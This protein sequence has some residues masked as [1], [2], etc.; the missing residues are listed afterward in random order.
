MIPDLGGSKPAIQQKGHRGVWGGGGNRRSPGS[1]PAV[2][3][4]KGG[5]V[6][7]LIVGDEDIA[8]TIR[9]A[10]RMRWPDS[11]V[12]IQDAWPARHL[13]AHEP[14]D[15]V[16]VW[17]AHPDL[18]ALAL[19]REIRDASDV[20][21]FFVGSSDTEMAAAE[22]LEAGADDYLALP[23]NEP[24][25]VARV[26]AVLRRVKQV[27]HGERPAVQCGD[28][29]IDPNSH[30]ARLNDR[31]LHLTP[32]E[33]KLLYHL[34]E[35]QGRVVTQRALEHVIWGNS[36]RLYLDVL[37]KHVQRLRQKLEAPRRGRMT[38]TTVPRVGYRLADQ[39][40]ARSRR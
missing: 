35:H 3:L 17:A 36:D 33:F 40:Q 37:R 20:V 2:R 6:R 25:L 11:K 30:E 13:L 12:V 32:T 1:R 16:F 27:A 24:L 19:V 4:S 7:A 31:P 8:A 38:I 9:L 28:L 18:D 34:V 5:T 23:I 29:L 26:C 15:V 22:A 10:L 39:K 14:P 21:I